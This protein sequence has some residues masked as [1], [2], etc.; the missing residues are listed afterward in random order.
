MDKSFNEEKV[1]GS[2]KKSRKKSRKMSKIKE[3]CRRKRNTRGQSKQEEGKL[4]T[5][6]NKT[7]NGNVNP[8][9]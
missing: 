6:R 3:I 7:E 9:K 4:Q 2:R 8:G 5:K 1:G